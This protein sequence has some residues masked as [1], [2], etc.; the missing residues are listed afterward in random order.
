[1]YF[2]LKLDIAI[3]NNYRHK[4]NLMATHKKYYQIL[5]LTY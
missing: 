5:S 2:D 4:I 3:K 1:M